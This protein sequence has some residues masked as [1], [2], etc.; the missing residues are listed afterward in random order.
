MDFYKIL[1]LPR[2]AS[3]IDI[4]KSFR[5]LALSFHPDVNGGDRLKTERFSEIKKAYDTLIDDNL[6]HSYDDR[7]GFKRASYTSSSS[8]SYTYA[9]S[10]NDYKDN[11][12]VNNVRNASSYQ[13]TQYN[14]SSSHHKRNINPEEWNAWLY[15]DN[16]TV[17][18]DPIAHT[19]SYMNLDPDKYKDYRYY[20]K[21]NARIREK[22]YS[23]HLQNLSSS[24]ATSSHCTPETA[25]DNLRQR[26]EERTKQE[27]Q[28]EAEDR[29]RNDSS[30]SSVYKRSASGRGATPDRTGDSSCIIQ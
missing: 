17:K 7:M 12:Y 30:Q 27:R 3:S 29:V 2:T 24:N 18:I 23:E 10:S 5:K 13:S 15:G 4:K 11:N 19:S 1:N 9:S 26:R 16:Y 28:T 20:S 22:L 25:S 8:A 21:K 6:R 14:Q